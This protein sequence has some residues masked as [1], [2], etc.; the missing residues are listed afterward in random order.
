MGT[1]YSHPGYNKY[2][3]FCQSAAIT[4]ADDKDPI[5]LPA[6]LISDDEDIQ[7]DNIEP[8]RGPSP[9]TIPKNPLLIR[10][11]KRERTQSTISEHTPDETPRELHLSPEQTGM[12]THKLPAVIEDDHLD[13]CR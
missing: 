2:D 6:H 5:A 7:Q 10:P 9:I 4:I 12:T 1:L 13:T 8:Q 3:L 11:K